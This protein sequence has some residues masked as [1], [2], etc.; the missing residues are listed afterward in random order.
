MLRNRDYLLR[1]RFRLLTSYGS[2]SGSVS[3]SSKSNLKKWC[4]NIAF[5]M[6]SEAA[7]LSR[8][9]SFQLLI[10]IFITVSVPLRQK[11]TVPTVPVSATLLWGGWGAP[12]GSLPGVRSPVSL[13]EPLLAEGHLAHTAGEGLQHLLPGPQAVLQRWDLAKN[14]SIKLQGQGHEMRIVFEGV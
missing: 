14:Q 8:N 11:V 6:L 2:S 7:L 10:F 1:F 9:L 5:L 4:K 3:R 12:E 13:E